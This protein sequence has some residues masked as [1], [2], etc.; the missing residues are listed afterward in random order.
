[1]GGM[2]QVTKRKKNGGGIIF[3]VIKSLLHR[4]YRRPGNVSRP[5]ELYSS[6]HNV[7]ILWPVSTG[8]CL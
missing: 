6:C 1:M 7:H 5:S 3:H 4:V 2:S 8:S